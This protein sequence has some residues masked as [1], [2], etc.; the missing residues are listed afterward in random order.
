MRSRRLLLGACLSFLVGACSIGKPFPQATTYIVS[1]PAD[2]AK[3]SSPELQ[4]ALRIGG[5][6]VA[7]P[8]AGRS[9]LYRFNE[10]RYV[11]DPYQA[12]GADTAAMLGG[13]I[14]EGLDDVGLFRTVL[15]PGSA[16][17][18]R[19]VLEV[20]VTELYGD[21]REGRSPAA[22]MS[23]QFTLVDTAGLRPSLMYERSIS[24]RI[25]LPRAAPEDLVR[26]YGT[27]LA[28]ILSQLVSELGVMCAYPR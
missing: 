9:L 10:V 6:R 25:P 15:Q 24:R 23:V 27:A 5:V 8:F 1:L 13:R 21:F 18:A 16:S 7:A 22:V 2:L 11:S 3:S 4:D 19:Y 20:S 26:G 12:F 14:A 28:G 17:P